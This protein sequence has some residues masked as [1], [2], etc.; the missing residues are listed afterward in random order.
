MNRGRI[1]VER[2]TPDF[3][4]AKILIADIE[5]PYDL[6]TRLKGLFIDSGKLQIDELPHDGNVV[7]E[8]IILDRPD[9]VV[10]NL[11]LRNKDGLYMLE[12]INKIVEYSPAVYV[13]AD[14]MSQHVLYRIKRAAPDL[15]GIKPI[16]SAVMAS[17]IE[18][19]L[20]FKSDYRGNFVTADF[21]PF[22]SNIYVR[23]ISQ[24]FTEM[25][26]P[27]KQYSA[28]TRTA[29]YLCALDKSFQYDMNNHLYPKVADMYH[30]SARN[31]IECVKSSVGYAARNKSPL[32]RK[33]FG[34]EVASAKKFLIK[35]SD[36]IREMMG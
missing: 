32:Y 22:A 31:V 7:E 13:L 28:R 3:K 21:E 18:S 1:A 25:G 36:L 33:H 24:I 30:I 11:A 8:R 35:I 12:T 27:D 4:K 29:V 10:F 23:A 14:Y 19:L 20:R 26:I 15:V 34:N 6:S 16:D 9:V 2:G 17:N 5:I